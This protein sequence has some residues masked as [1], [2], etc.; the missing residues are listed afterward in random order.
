MT[1]EELVAC[2]NAAQK[3]QTVTAAV[4]ELLVAAQRQDR[5]TVGVY[6]SAKLM[7]VDPDSVVLCL[8]AIDEEEEEE[9]GSERPPWGGDPEAVPGAAAEEKGGPR[10]AGDGTPELRPWDGAEAGVA[11]RTAAFPVAEGPDSTREWGDTDWTPHPPWDWSWRPRTRDLVERGSAP[12]AGPHFGT[13]E[14]GLKLL[15]THELPVCK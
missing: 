7:N 13:R 3:M 6:E 4:E 1:L 2:D 12:S 10:P 15:C 8:L 14:L 9:K 11:G 5:L